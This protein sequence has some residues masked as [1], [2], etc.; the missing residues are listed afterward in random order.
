[1]FFFRLVVSSV[2]RQLAVRQV[3]FATN[4]SLTPCPLP[5]TEGWKTGDSGEEGP[6]AL[7]DVV[8]LGILYCSLG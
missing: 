1:M 6:A 4:P 8:I 7:K 2:N 3:F 5:R